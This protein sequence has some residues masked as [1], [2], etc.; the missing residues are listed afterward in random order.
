M[1][2]EIETV[3][4]GGFQIMVQWISHRGESA[5]APENTLP[6]FKLALERDTDGIETDIH[7]TA[8]KVLVC[9]HDADTFRTCQGISCIIEKTN[10]ADLQGMDASFSKS[11]Y[12]VVGIPRFA[13][14]FQYLGKGKAYYVEIKD[15][16]PEVADVMLREIDEAGIDRKQIVMISFHADVVRAYKAKYPEMESLWLYSCC[17]PDGRTT[18]EKC[19]EVLKIAKEIKAD[20][21][22]LYIPPQDISRELVQ[23]FHDAGL[24]FAVWTIDQCAVAKKWVEAGVDAITSNCAAKVRTWVEQH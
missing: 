15:N 9:C 18:E 19:D 20:G 17:T 12:G 2:S 4:R 6:A 22:D 16:N 10:W 21:V 8:D 23:K 7:L 13:E 14:S 3:N 1:L 5:D 11:G 24:K